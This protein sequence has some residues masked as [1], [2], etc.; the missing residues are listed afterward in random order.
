MKTKQPKLY[1][2]EKGI[3]I[4]PEARATNGRPGAVALTLQRL[5]KGDSFLVRE[6]LEALKARKI[7]RDAS[8]KNGRGYT[9]RKAGKGVRIWRV[10]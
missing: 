9:T 5:E 7:V 2:I 8:K 3:R 1:K 4:P 10:R 6:E